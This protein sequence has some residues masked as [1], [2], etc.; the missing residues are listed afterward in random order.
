[1]NG[2]NNDNLKENEILVRLF[3]KRLGYKEEII[4]KVCKVIR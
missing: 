1:M 3:L 4:D 2:N